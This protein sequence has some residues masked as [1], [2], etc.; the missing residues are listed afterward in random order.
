MQNRSFLIAVVL[1]VAASI[2]AQTIRVFENGVLQFESA[3]ADSV[4]FVK[5]EDE[6]V[7]PRALDGVF[8]VSKQTKVRF[9]SGNVQYQASTQQWRFAPKQYDKVGSM[10]AAIGATNKEWMD[11]FG[12]GTG[13]TPTQSSTDNNDYG[14]FVDWGSK[15]SKEYAWRTLSADEWNY[16]FTERSNADNLWARAT[17]CG[18]IGLLLC[19]D[20]W[21]TK[22]AAGL[23]QQGIELDAQ[24]SYDTNVFAIGE[25][26]ALEASGVVFLP[27]SGIRNGKDV[28]GVCSYGYYAS[29]SPFQEGLASYVFF[30]SDFLTLGNHTNRSF[31][32]A[33]RLVVEN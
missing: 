3:T 9:G 8:S 31:G 25:W 14:A 10:N 2:Q 24:G 12:W 20:N 30:D 16:L 6:P 18:V 4:A 33:V 17:V 7:A 28:Y 11:L 22:A 15:I 23:A 32:L 26:Q 29:S 27:A 1:I 13:N 5:S 19:P 21:Q